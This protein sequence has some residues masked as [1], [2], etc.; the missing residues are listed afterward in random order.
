MSEIFD[1]AVKTAEYYGKPDIDVA[2]IVDAFYE[3]RAMY[4]YIIVP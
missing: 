4:I 1:Y 3:F 2:R